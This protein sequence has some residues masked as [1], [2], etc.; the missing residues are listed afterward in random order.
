M[1]NSILKSPR[2]IVLATMIN[3]LWEVSKQW[4]GQPVTKVWSVSQANTL[5]NRITSDH[6]IPVT[7]RTRAKNLQ[8]AIIKNNA[9][10]SYRRDKL[11]L[12]K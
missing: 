8:N 10:P 1:T 7:T 3:D 6:N 5:L 2:A 12:Q 11:K 4:N 9:S